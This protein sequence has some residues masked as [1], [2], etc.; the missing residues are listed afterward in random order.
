MLNVF[1]KGEQGL[2]KFINSKQ[3]GFVVCRV[4]TIINQPVAIR[5][6]GINYAGKFRK[7]TTGFEKL[8]KLLLIRIEKKDNGNFRVTNNKTVN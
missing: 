2:I 8:N 1:D 6:K 7:Q 5:Y 4:S 3:T